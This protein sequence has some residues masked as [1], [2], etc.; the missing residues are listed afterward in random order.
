V[1]V[2][3]VMGLGFGLLLSGCGGS[4]ATSSSSGDVS[5]PTT[6]TALSKHQVMDAALTHFLARVKPIRHRFNQLDD[7]LNELKLLNVCCTN[8]TA[9]ERLY[10]VAAKQAKRAADKLAALQAPKPVERVYLSY[11]GSYRAAGL[12]DSELAYTL[13]QQQSFSWVSFNSQWNAQG[14]PVTKFRVALIAYAAANHLRLPRWV[15]TIGG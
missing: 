13:H 14:A 2:I 3:A 7:R 15:H 1:R 8:W 11:V 9:G 4:S 5:A 6:T 12:T 10:K